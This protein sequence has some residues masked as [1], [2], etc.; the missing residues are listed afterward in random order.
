MSEQLYIQQRNALLHHPLFS[1]P[2]LGAWSFYFLVKVGLAFTDQIELHLL[3]NYALFAFLVIPVPYR[4]IKVIRQI[5]AV[6]AA[7][8][9]LYVESHL[10]PFERLVS[11][12][13][14][15][16]HFS[17]WYILELLGR[18]IA[19]EMIAIFL[20]AWIL[21]MYLAKILRMT[22]ISLAALLTF[23]LWPQPNMTTTPQFATIGPAPRT[24]E[25][26][27]VQ[28]IEQSPDSVLSQFY[29][30][31][32]RIQLTPPP[33]A[34]DF[35]ILMI[36][37]CSL[38]WQ[39]IEQFELTEHTF[40]QRA[41]IILNNFYTGSSYSG[42]ATLR[43][44]QA[45]CGHRPHSQIFNPDNACLIGSQLEQLGFRSEIRLNH[46]GAFD[47]FLNQIRTIGGLTNASFIEPSQ[48]PDSM[49]GFDQSPIQSDLAVLSDWLA[50][51]DTQPRFTFY[52]STSLHD[53]NR[54][55][56]FRGNSSA[57]YRTR[58]LTLLD[59]LNQ[60][61]DDIEASGAK[62][63]VVIVPEHGAGLQGDRMQLPGMR[64]IPTP[65][66]T[67]VPVMFKLFGVEGVD[68]QLIN[69]SRPT[70]PLAITTAIYQI[71]EQQPFSGGRY[72]PQEVVDR[73]PE[74]RAV[75]END[76]VIMIEIDGVF[77]LQINN[78]EWREYRG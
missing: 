18:L 9:L 60:L 68:I 10:P 34:A 4:T 33:V 53:G 43:L 58:L 19:V 42:P 1:W 76:R 73:L 8:V 23:P 65:A 14:L 7:V 11:Q 38:S 66:L 25:T 77:Y 20:V 41:D 70:G 67:H 48:F 27:S 37:I 35:D 16:S 49:M 3:W 51:I 78:G 32:Q 2:G 29:S 54:L 44:L 24:I 6:I 40:F 13:E 75:L 26:S 36:N 5:L 62:T 72:N 64:E 12:W 63:L 28:P 39:D 71:I 30:T 61:F 57:S 56:G 31:Q 21:Y 22:A 74:T 15:V 50:T 69:A 52:N 55:P 46:T 47:N 17:T 45:N 59:D